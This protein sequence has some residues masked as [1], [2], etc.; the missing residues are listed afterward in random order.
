MWYPRDFSLR[1]NKLTKVTV[2]VIAYSL[3]Y[4]KCEQSSSYVNNSI[5]YRR[6][7]TLII[8]YGIGGRH[9]L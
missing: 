7:H 8:A 1:K 3:A 6:G 4:K 9:M 2:V 5:A